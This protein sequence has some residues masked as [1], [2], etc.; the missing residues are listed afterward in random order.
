VRVRACVCVLAWRKVLMLGVPKS[1]QHLFRNVFMILA[2]LY[3]C[4]TN[5]FWYL[6]TL[7]RDFLRICEVCLVQRV[8]R[9]YKWS[10]ETVE[11]WE[12]MKVK[13]LL[14]L[15]HLANYCLDKL[16]TEERK[17]AIHFIFSRALTFL[18]NTSVI[19]KCNVCCTVPQVLQRE[20]QGIDIV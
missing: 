11:T 13:E 8:A 16:S 12:D 1:E 4:T 17:D 7:L 5:N 6:Y 10:C 3:S 2:S 9:A 20:I 19:K 15:C 14:W 18:F